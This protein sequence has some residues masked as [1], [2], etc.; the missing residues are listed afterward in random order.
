MALAAYHD[1]DHLWQLPRFL[2]ARALGYRFALGH[3]TMHDKE[4]VLY[5]WAR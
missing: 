3:F 2:A 1:I 5:A 4:T